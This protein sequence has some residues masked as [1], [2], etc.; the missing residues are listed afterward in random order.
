[1]VPAIAFAILVATGFAQMCLFW[2]PLNALFTG[3]LPAEKWIGGFH[4]CW[5]VV[6]FSGT[7]AL[8]HQLVALPLGDAGMWPVNFAI[9]L[10]DWYQSR[11]MGVFRFVKV[12]AAIEFLAMLFGA[13]LILPRITRARIGRSD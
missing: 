3:W 8:L 1:M 4:W 13:A 2:V 7:Y 9:K 11:T 5:G 6:M 12:V 10:K